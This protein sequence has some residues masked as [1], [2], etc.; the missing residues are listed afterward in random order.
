M[1][2]GYIVGQYNDYDLPLFVIAG[3]LALSAFLFTRIDASR[4]L[5][6]EAAMESTAA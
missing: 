6:P 2:F 4:P 1:L 5:F 3:M